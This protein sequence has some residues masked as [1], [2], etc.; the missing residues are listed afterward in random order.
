ME[1]RWS[2]CW[3]ECLRN[4]DG[5]KTGKH[6][7]DRVG[8]LRFASPGWGPGLMQEKGSA[9]RLPVLSRTTPGLFMG[10]DGMSRTHP[11]ALRVQVGE[12]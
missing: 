3:E 4:V 10:T 7:R 11:S 6:S 5:R 2:S 8:L 9:A 1:S 12:R